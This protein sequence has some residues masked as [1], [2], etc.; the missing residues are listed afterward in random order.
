MLLD[1]AGRDGVL[2]QRAERIEESEHVD[3]NDGWFTLVVW[4][5]KRFSK[6][7]ASSVRAR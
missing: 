6:G 2:D 5:E 4:R 7:R 1:E 3:K